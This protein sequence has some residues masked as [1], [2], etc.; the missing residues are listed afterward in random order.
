MM[1]HRAIQAWTTR[2]EGLAMS[3]WRA[4]AAHISFARQ[5]QASGDFSDLGYV[6]MHIENSSEGDKYPRGGWKSGGRASRP[7]LQETERVR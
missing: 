6:P 5:A 3:A 4:G 1:D 7:S 2:K